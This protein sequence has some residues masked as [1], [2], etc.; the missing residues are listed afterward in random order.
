MEINDKIKLYRDKITRLK[1]EAES[2]EALI[3]KAKLSYS[4]LIDN[5]GDSTKHMIVSEC[6]NLLDKNYIDNLDKLSYEELQ[7]FIKSN[8]ELME[9]LM[10]IVEESLS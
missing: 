6:P 5:I 1:I 2:N 3:N 10:T 7:G 8:K 9:K 4:R